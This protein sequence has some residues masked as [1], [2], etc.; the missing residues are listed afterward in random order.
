MATAKKTETTGTELAVNAEAGLPAEL[1]GMMEADAGKGISENPND[2]GIPFI[3]VLQD[4]SPQV[5]KRDEKYVE[6]AEV[7]MLINS[8]TSELYPFGVEFLPV[9][10]ESCHVE[11]VPRDAGGGYKGKHPFDTPLLRDAR[12]N[13]EGK[14]APRLPNGNDLV[15]T[16][17]WYGFYRPLA[18]DG[19]TQAG[20]R[21]EPGVIAFSS[22]GLKRSREWVGLTKK[23]LIPGTESVAPLFSHVYVVTTKVEKKN[24]NEWFLPAIAA[25]RWVTG[26]E[27]SIAKTFHEQ[28]ATGAVNVSAPDGGETDL[29]EDVV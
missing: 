20:T 26:D 11:W 29:A 21:W 5:K 12:P 4:L 15:E 22:T 2:V 6:G 28:A 27:Y 17:Y 10:Y 16:R 3:A 7:G 24:N 1:M 18:E 19:K 14:G 8:V 9:Y 23:F 25:G 13:P